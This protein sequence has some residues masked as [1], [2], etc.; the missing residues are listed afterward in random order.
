MHAETIKYRVTRTLLCLNRTYF[1]LILYFLFRYRYTLH[2]R[3][4][5][6]E[7]ALFPS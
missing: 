1:Y 7:N 2:V 5:M 6:L 3:S 4:R